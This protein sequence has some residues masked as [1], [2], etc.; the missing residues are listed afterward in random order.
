[1]AND[2]TAL[3]ALKEIIEDNGGTSDAQT[4]VPAIEDLGEV[5]AAGGGGGGGIADGSVT[6]AKLANG[7]VTTDKLALGA[8]T[9]NEISN[10]LY[11]ELSDIDYVATDATTQAVMANSGQ[12]AVVIA[13]N[14]FGV[15]DASNDSRTRLCWFTMANGLEVAPIGYM[16]DLQGVITFYARG[17]RTMASGTTNDTSWTITALPTDVDG[18][19]Y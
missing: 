9:R 18:V 16:A 5:I 17:L 4:L 1:M 7:A 3:G 12:P 15:S 13:P 19:S 14:A 6:T 10:S 2:G 8:V 11:N